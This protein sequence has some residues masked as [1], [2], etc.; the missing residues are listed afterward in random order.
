[1]MVLKED[2]QQNVRQVLWRSVDS[3]ATGKASI[4]ERLL[5]PGIFLTSLGPGQESLPVGSRHKLEEIIQ[6]FTKEGTIEAT[7]RMMS[8]DEAV[9]LANQILSLY[10]ELRGGI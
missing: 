8:D 10:V 2:K 3:L 5:S 9:K 4:K 1:M 6:S 7:L